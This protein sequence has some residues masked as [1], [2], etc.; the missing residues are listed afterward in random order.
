MAN[1]EDDPKYKDLMD[2][3][4]KANNKAA[5]NARKGLITRIAALFGAGMLAIWGRKIVDTIHD[6]DTVTADNRPAAE[7]VLDESELEDTTYNK[8][9]EDIMKRREE[10][11]EKYNNGP[12]VND[13]KRNPNLEKN[14]YEKIDE[15]TKDIQEN[16]NEPVQ[17]EKEPTSESLPETAP[18]PPET[19]PSEAAPS[20]TAP[21]PSE[22][23]QQPQAEREIRSV[24]TVW[25]PNFVMTQSG[26]P[27]HDPVDANKSYVKFVVTYSDGTQDI[28]NPIFNFHY[29]KPV[30]VTAINENHEATFTYEYTY[31]GVRYEKQGIAICSPD[32]ESKREEKSNEYPD[33]KGEGNGQ[34]E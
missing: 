6:N 26:F 20:E 32:I 24:E 5:R 4:N 8:S 2:A 25:N 9:V 30:D 18:A 29:V 33:I 11:R 16:N 31:K 12:E 34:Y 21:A 19:A 14:G 13:N 22:T 10:L 15:G 23:V 17:N 28:D 3:R 7:K 27:Y 1:F